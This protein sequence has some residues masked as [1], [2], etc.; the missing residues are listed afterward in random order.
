MED[1]P[2]VMIVD[3]N[4]TSLRFV[5]EILNPE[6]ELATAST[7]EEALTTIHKSSLAFR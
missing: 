6:F 5:S 2:K 7:G 3:D 1:K 4:Q